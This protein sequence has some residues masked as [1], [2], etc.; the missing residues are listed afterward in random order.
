L[1]KAF[2]TARHQSGVTKPVCVHSL[3]H[4]YTSWGLNTTGKR[5]PGRAR[6]NWSTGQTR[7]KVT[8]KKN[9]MPESAIRSRRA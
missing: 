8:A 1:R 3:R 7:P 5:R 9:L 6:A 2:H 4:A